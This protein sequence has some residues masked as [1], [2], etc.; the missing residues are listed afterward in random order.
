M[1]LFKLALLLS[2]CGGP[3]LIADLLKPMIGQLEA[4]AITFAPLAVTGFCALYLEDD[5]P[6]NWGREAALAG[7]VG[8]AIVAM[9]NAFAVWQLATGPE[10]A[11][12]S[13][14][15]FGIVV[16]IV[17]SAVYVYLAR[18]RLKQ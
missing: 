14:N 18:R 12:G 10:R 2:F 9:M 13:L 3:M 17:S 16:G 8:V 7:L 15:A 4:F 6:G 5:E 1:L 11:D